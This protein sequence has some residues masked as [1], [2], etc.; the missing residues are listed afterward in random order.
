M[1]LENDL[2]FVMIKPDGYEHKGEIESD[3]HDILNLNI[4][5]KK[6]D[7]NVS[8]PLAEIHYKE[9][10]NE[11]YFPRSVNQLTSGPTEALIIVGENALEKIKEKAGPTDPESAKVNSPYSWRAMF[12][13]ALPNNA[14]HRAANSNAVKR[15]TRIHFSVAELAENFP[16][17][18]LEYIYD[19]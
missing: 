17:D 16:T 6:V 5:A 12:G 2:S 1:N 7:Y 9:N 3:I 11:W 19:I 4:V 14:I 10:R 13:T 15:E 18:L 8:K